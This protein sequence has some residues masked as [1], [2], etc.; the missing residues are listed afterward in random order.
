MRCSLVAVTRFIWGFT[1]GF[2]ADSIWSAA[3]MTNG[4]GGPGGPAKKPDPDGRRPAAQDLPIL[5][6]G[7]GGGPTL[8]GPGTRRRLFEALGGRDNIEKVVDRFYDRIDG[9]PELRPVFPAN[10]VVG[11]ARQKL[12]LEEWLGG[13]PRYSSEIGPWQL[14]RRHAPFRVTESGAARWIDHMEGALR[15]CGAPDDLASE[16]ASLLRPVAFRMVNTP[17]SE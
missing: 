15:D 1:W 14:R 9:D 8:G 6:T 13:E 4:Q 7:P 2:A 11:R 10:M 17:D 12:F 5:N 16:I 3:R